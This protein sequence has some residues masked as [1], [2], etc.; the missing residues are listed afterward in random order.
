MADINQQEVRRFLYRYLLGRI[1]RY[2]IY[3]L[4]QL[5]F[6]FLQV[7]LPVYQFSI[8]SN[9]PSL[10]LQLLRAQ[11]L[12]QGLRQ[13][14]TDFL[15]LQCGWRNIGSLGA[16]QYIDPLRVKLYILLKGLVSTYSIGLVDSVNLGLY[17]VFHYNTNF[18]YKGGGQGQSF[19]LD[20]LP[21]L[22]IKV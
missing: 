7:I 15:S 20:K 12:Y 11:I 16:A 14:T 8:L 10:L 21:S 17:K 1:L 4:L 9:I 6:Y 22:Y 19:G 18:F 13:I 2:R 5:I 3:S